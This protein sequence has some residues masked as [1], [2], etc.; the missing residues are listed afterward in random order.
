MELQN[1]GGSISVE[2]PLEQPLENKELYSVKAESLPAK[3]PLKEDGVLTDLVEA[4]KIK[5]DEGS[6][7]NDHL[8]E[9]EQ[10]KQCRNESGL[11][12]SEPKKESSRDDSY[13]TENFKIEIFGLPKYTGY[14]QLKKY[15]K[16]LG[17]EPKKVWARM[18]P[19]FL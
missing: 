15:L 6:A 5:L 11:N 1:D 7:A 4:K 9:G 16:N 13:T 14:G 2:Y 12:E 17:L 3:R 18:S 19:L 10:T 8:N